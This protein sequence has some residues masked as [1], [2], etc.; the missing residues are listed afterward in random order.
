MKVALIGRA[1]V[2]MAAS[3]AVAPCRTMAAQTAAAAADGNAEWWWCWRRRCRRGW[4][5]VK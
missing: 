1:L 5:G 3:V 4:P 2:A